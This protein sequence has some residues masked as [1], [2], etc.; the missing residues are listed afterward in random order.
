MGAQALSTAIPLGSVQREQAKISISQV[1]PG[2]DL[3]AYFPSY[4]LKVQLLTGLCVD[5]IWD[6]PRSPQALPLRV[7]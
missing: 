3:T 7:L 2:K 4:C 5:A 6:S 1:L